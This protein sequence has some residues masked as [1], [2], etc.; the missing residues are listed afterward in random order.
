MATGL[1]IGRTQTKGQRGEEFGER[2][3]AA[4]SL[5]ESI[6]GFIQGLFTSTFRHVS[7]LVATKVIWCDLEKS[8]QASISETCW[9]KRKEDGPQ[10]SWTFLSLF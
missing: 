4:G 9:E 5:G 7:Q 10:W 8:A 6:I 3:D 1:E 2:F